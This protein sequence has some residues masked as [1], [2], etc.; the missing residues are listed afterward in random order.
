MISILAKKL[1]QDITKRG[2]ARVS[3]LSL[4]PRSENMAAAICRVNSMQYDVYT[5]TEVSN[6]K[7]SRRFRQFCRRPRKSIRSR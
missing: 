7:P 3:S 5:Q 1:L 6:G 4:V 2:S